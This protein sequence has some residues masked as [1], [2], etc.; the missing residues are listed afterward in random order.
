M[1]AIRRFASAAAVR[2]AALESPIHTGPIACLDADRQ[3]RAWR[4]VEE[5]Y[6]A[7]EKDGAIEV[8]AEWLVLGAS[9]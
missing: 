9:R 6:A 7:L 8:P 4:R 5:G 3:A 1:R 2:T